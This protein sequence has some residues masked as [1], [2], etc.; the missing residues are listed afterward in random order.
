M[1]LAL[2]GQQVFSWAIHTYMARL[3]RYTIYFYSKLA[4]GIKK[5]GG[6]G[7]WWFP[8]CLDLTFFDFLDSAKFFSFFFFHSFFSYSVLAK[9]ANGTD[10]KSKLLVGIPKVIDHDVD[11]WNLIDF[12]SVDLNHRLSITLPCL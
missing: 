11:D 8:K 10:F 1:V 4:C 2:Q 9:E 5:G 12:G 6:W 3:V 7:I